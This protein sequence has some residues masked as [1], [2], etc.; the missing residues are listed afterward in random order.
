MKSAGLVAG[1]DSAEVLVKLFATVDRSCAD[2]VRDSRPD[3]VIF[4]KK[5]GRP[6]TG[7]PLV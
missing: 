2:N 4:Q 7:R 5:N 6:I 3:L 1:L